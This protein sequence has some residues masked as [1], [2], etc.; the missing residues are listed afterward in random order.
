MRIQ[1]DPA[2][3]TRSLAE[4]IADS[5]DAASS[6]PAAPASHAG[7]SL[8]AMLTPEEREFFLS[9][10]ALGPLTYR[11]GRRPASAPAPPTGQ[12]LDVKG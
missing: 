12:R 11:R 7:S 8:W 2:A 6:R 5:L 4:R 1:S 3:G 9:Q 10:A